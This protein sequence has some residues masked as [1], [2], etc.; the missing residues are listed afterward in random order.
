MFKIKYFNMLYTNCL[1][2]LITILFIPRFFLQLFCQCEGL[3]RWKKLRILNQTNLL[4]DSNE[5]V[6]D[7]YKYKSLKT[8]VGFTCNDD[9]GW[10]YKRSI[11]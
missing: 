1:K 4:I 6:I 9:T 3:A 5:F 11:Y 7:Y 8:I 10:R 2:Y